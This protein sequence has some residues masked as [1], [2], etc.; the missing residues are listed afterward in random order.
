MKYL[1]YPH[2]YCPYCYSKIN[3]PTEYFCIKCGKIASDKNTDFNVDYRGLPLCTCG[4][5]AMII[6]CTTDRCRNS[7]NIIPPERT[8]IVLIAGMANSGKSTFLLD[9][10]SSQSNLT[11]VLVSP[12][13]HSLIEWRKKSLDIMKNG[14]DLDSTVPENDNFSSVVSMKVQGRKDELCLSLTDRPGEETQDLNKMLG[15]NYVFCAD[16]IILLIDLLN[17]PGIKDELKSKGVEVRDETDDEPNINAIENIINAVDNKRG[18]YGRKIPFMVGISKWDYVEQA[19]LCPP[20][21]SIGCNGSDLSS[22]LGVN[23]KFDSKK[24]KSNTKAIRNFL[25]T[26]N[27]AEVVNKL[28]DYFKDVSYFAFSSY[29]S[30]PKGTSSPIHSPRHIMDPFYRILHDKRMI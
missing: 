8:A 18:K 20:G 2:E 17:I 6:R 14:G 15:L 16:Y 24:W 11:N 4:N 22:V 9:V 13:S 23:R 10:V 30:V 21:F 3:V 12:K 5:G 1:K 27:E 19:D 7:N 25:V 26:H 28:E 29:G